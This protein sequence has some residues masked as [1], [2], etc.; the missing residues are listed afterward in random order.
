MIKT[1]HFLLGF[2]FSFA[3][4]VLVGG[5]LYDLQGPN[6]SF[7]SYFYGITHA[8]PFFFLF[9]QLGV[10]LNIGLFFLTINKPK[11]FWICRGLSIGTIIQ[12]FYIVYIF[13]FVAL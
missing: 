2:L 4:F 7:S 13:A 6:Y 11:W 1:V 10:A 9:Y 12:V 3:S 5:L 8:E